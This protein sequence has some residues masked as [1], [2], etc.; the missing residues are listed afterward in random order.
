MQWSVKTTKNHKDESFFSWAGTTKK[1]PTARV[2]DHDGVDTTDISLSVCDECTEYFPS[3][4]WYS[5]PERGLSC[6]LLHAR[7]GQ[8]LSSPISTLGLKARQSWQRLSLSLEKGSSILRKKLRLPASPAE[9]TVHTD[10]SGDVK[11]S[12]TAGFGKIPLLIQSYPR[13]L[14]PRSFAN[15]HLAQLDFQVFNTLT[16]DSEYSPHI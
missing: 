9:Q 4:I 11:N 6:F 10:D 8:P 13:V 1:W 15:C 7:D 12:F 14:H 3:H 5:D 2:N 16:R